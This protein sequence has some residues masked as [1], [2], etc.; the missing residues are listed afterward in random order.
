M[1]LSIPLTSGIHSAKTKNHMTRVAQLPQISMS[2]VKGKARA[3]HIQF[4]YSMIPLTKQSDH[5]KESRLLY[6][7][8]DI[9]Q[10]CKTQLS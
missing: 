9:G 1:R 8:W 6:C 5:N 7:L 2:R 4:F 3:V 10:I